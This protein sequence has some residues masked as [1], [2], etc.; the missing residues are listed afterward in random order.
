[1]HRRSNETVSEFNRRFENFYFS[2]PTEIHPPE[3][4]TMVYYSSSL[5]LDVAFYLREKGS[6]TLEQISI[7]AQEVKDNLWASGKLPGQDLHLDLE[8]TQQAKEYKQ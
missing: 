4:A 7:D 8:I 2:I 6:K 3:A 5:H 1:M